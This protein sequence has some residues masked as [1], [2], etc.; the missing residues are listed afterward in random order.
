MSIVDRDTVG[1]LR[2]FPNCVSSNKVRE[3][4]MRYV[5]TGR[6]HPERVAAGFDHLKLASAVGW[7]AVVSC[8]WSKISVVLDF[9][10]DTDQMSY[11]EPNM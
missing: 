4:S 3:S 10:D 7:K 8:Q 6:I 1:N 9:P 5:C 11:L 2:F